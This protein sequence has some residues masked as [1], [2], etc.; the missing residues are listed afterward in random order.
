[1]P[2][3]LTALAPPEIDQLSTD[4]LLRWAA[5][6][7]APGVRAWR[8]GDAVAVATPE[9]ANRDRLVLHGPVT[10]AAEL[11]GPAL[12]H[13]GPSYRAMGAREL[14]VAVSER[15][16]WPVPHHSFG[17]MQTTGVPIVADPRARA[18][19]AADLPG[20]GELIERS[21]PDSYGRPGRAGVRSWWVV[22]GPL[23][24]LACAA[25]AWSA[26]TVGLLAG[27]V[28]DHRQRGQGLGRAV[29]TAALAGLLASY[30]QAALL[31]DGDNTPARALYAS[32][33]MSYRELAASGPT[34]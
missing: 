10:D 12:A 15:R 6:G 25:D 5:Q 8:L 31:V 11:V 3:S 17:W 33:G 2:P 7:G 26:P 28:T 32:L 13:C 21:F 23:G 16:G 34:G 19:T 1:M 29:V 4:P 9:L 18:A 22:P 14:I 20:I 30:G 27:V 24:I